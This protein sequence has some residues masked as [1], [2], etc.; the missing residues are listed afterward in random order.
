MKTRLLGLAATAAV[1]F[2]LAPLPAGAAVCNIGNFPSYGAF[3]FGSINNGFGASSCPNEVTDKAYYSGT[4]IRNPGSPLIG[5]ANGSIGTDVWGLSSASANLASGALSV[6]ATSL[7]K[8][9]FSGDPEPF[10]SP[11]GAVAG[12]YVSLIFSGGE[13]LTGSIT[14]SG[15]LSYVG[16]VSVTALPAVT[17]GGWQG[18]LGGFTIVA[19]NNLPATTNAPWSLTTNFTIH[20]GVPYTMLAYLQATTSGSFLPGQVT[21]TD[22]LSFD[23][24]E[25]V[26]FTASD[27][28]FLT[29][30]SGV[31][32]PSTWAMMLI[33]FAGIGF[34]AYRRSQRALSAA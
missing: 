22:P 10:G 13:G 26:T 32:E 30:V 25:G 27:P 20:D 28:L 29:Q 14:M 17:P 1:A 31:P 3:V 19:G 5:S 9:P 24:P 12:Y 6:S 7:H 2:D 16:N 8:P 33:G 21:V 15:L 11:A 34:M 18:I 4:D 23:L